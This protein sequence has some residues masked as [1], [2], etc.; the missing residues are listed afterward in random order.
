MSRYSKHCLRDYSCFSLSGSSGRYS[1]QAANQTSA[2][3][4]ATNHIPICTSVHEFVLQVYVGWNFGHILG[5]EKV[6]RETASV[7]S[8]LMEAQA[9]PSFGKP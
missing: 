7:P 1:N 9:P 8:I 6:R 2:L 4:G 3:C 5:A